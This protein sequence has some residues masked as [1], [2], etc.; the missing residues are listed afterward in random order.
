M[1]FA[2]V[3]FRVNFPQTGF[4]RKQNDGTNESLLYNPIAT[5]CAQTTTRHVPDDV[6]RTG[7]DV[8]AH[9]PALRISER[10]SL[11]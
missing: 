10:L 4:D 6:L 5:F 11:M 9:R 1:Q 8:S 7:R 3:L 2:A